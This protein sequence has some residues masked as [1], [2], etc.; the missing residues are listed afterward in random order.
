MDEKH[1]HKMW[2]HLFQGRYKAKV[3]DD[4][5][6]SYFRKVADYIHLN[7][8]AAGL[9]RK[10]DPDLKQYAWSSYTDYLKPP[11]QR[12][13]W[14]LVDHVLDAHWIGRDTPKGRKAFEASM[15]PLV[16]SVLANRAKRKW[17]QEWARYE[18]GWVHG[19]REFRE[20]IVEHLREEDEGLL[21]RVYDGEKGRSYNEYAASEAIEEGL[22]VLG[23]IRPDLGRLKKGDPRKLLLAGFIKRHFMVKNA[24]V[25]EQLNL[26]HPSRA[27]KATHVFT[28]PPAGL[29]K[30][31]RN[32]MKMF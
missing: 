20:R 17:K 24:W 27:S 8:A 3:I 1:H 7:P 6:A 16:L 26:G 32:L 13:A 10:E 2:G 15:F 29:K 22:K 30:A 12:P 5:D 4:S 21:R 18:R 11:R 25:S 31:K 14:L 23:M 19:S 9:L 28:N